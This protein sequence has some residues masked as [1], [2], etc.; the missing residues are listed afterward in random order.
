MDALGYIV[1]W[2]LASISVGVVI[3]ILSRHGRGKGEDEKA[4]KRE[5]QAMLQMMAELLGAAEQ[6]TGNVENHNTEI[7]NSV[8]QVDHLH[9]TGEM[10]I[11]K[12]VLL[13]HMKTL[14]TANR[15]MQEDLL[16]TRYRLEE[17]AQQ[18]DHARREARSDE[19][20]GVANRKA[21]Y[22]KLHL[23]MDEWRRQR[24]PFVLILA[25][26]DQFKWVNDAHGHLAGDRVLNAVGTRL[27]QLVRE[28]DF[29]GRY[30]GDEF[31]ILVPRAELGVGM[32]IAEIIRCGTSDKACHVAVRGGELSVSLSVGVA[33]PCEGDTDESIMHRVDS[34]MYKA[35][36]LG[37]NQVQCCE[38]E[39]EPVPV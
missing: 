32:E 23:L 3:G 4:Y 33:A 39:E 11:I 2:V 1:P 37:R 7:Q 34:A 31:A 9:V 26:L 16:C 17:Q 8:Q 10:D 38:R 24:T 15:Q 14:L 13:S 12:Q 28:G 30:G 35:K 36:R 25:D 29:V 20:T 19:L 27:K 6:I 22:E 18:I 21:F 5:R